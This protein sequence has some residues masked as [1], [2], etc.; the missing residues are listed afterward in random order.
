M[1]RPRKLW[2]WKDRNAWFATINGV[3][4]NL[5][6]EKAPAEKQF[7]KLMAADEVK[8]A[9]SNSP[10]AIEVLDK[11]LAWTKA[12]RAERTYDWYR[13]HIQSFIDSLSNQQLAADDQARG[14]G[15]LSRADSMP[16]N[17][18]TTLVMPIGPSLRITR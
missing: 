7:H 6:K 13:D 12:N 5:G 2:F 16:S 10:I 9:A 15:L 8:V 17:S 4:H 14:C 18:A 11:F 3:R 1:A